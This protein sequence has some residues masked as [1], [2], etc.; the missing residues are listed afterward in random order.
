MTYTGTMQDELIATVD[1][2]LA[3]RESSVNRAEP[4]G[5]LVNARTHLCRHEMTQ[6]DVQA[7]YQMADLQDELLTAP[8][9][10]S[11]LDK[12]RDETLGD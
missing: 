5:I 10:Y 7:W 4:W 8:D 11:I 12:I 2:V 3:L 9:G 1:N 6:G